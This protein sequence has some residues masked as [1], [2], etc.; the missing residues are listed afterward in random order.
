M[1]LVSILSTVVLVAIMI[2]L[3]LAVASYVV[4]RL[5]DIRKKKR[6][7][8]AKKGQKVGPKY[9]DRHSPGGSIGV[10]Q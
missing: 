1:E 2:T 3:V 4:Y 7:S 9:F 8:E 10:G 6:D 5:R